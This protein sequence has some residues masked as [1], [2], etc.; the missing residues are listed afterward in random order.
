MPS[1][2]Q[3]R[4]NVQFNR[5]WLASLVLCTAGSI[6]ALALDFQSRQRFFERFRPYSSYASA[7][8]V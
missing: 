7:G 3:I 4:I 8:D 5:V 2:V 1:I 6:P